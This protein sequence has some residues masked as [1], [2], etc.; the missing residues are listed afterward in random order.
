M[1]IE[2]LSSEPVT[3]NG[4]N[5]VL[6]PVILE[7]LSDAE[8]I[9]IANECQNEHWEDDSIIRRLAKQFYGGDSLT[10]IMFVA[11]KVLP[12]ITERL[13]CCSPHL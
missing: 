5:T 10:Q 11:L 4:V 6:A 3:A 9:E 1:K 13:K 2:N 12:V 7:N 8:L